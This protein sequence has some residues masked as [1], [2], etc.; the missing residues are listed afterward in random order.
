MKSWFLAQVPKFLE[1]FD[2]TLPGVSCLTIYDNSSNHGCDA[3][4]ALRCPKDGFNRNAGGKNPPCMR[5]GFY[6]SIDCSIVQQSMYFKNGDVILYQIE[7][8]HP[9]GNG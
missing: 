8:D 7:K 3:K 1:E 6:H 2:R 9:I 5:G 4:D